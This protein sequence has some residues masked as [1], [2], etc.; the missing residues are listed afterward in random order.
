M[1]RELSKP[2]KTS[3]EARE[4]MEGAV[5]VMASPEAA[6]GVYSNFAVIKHTALEFVFDFIFNV[7][8]RGQLV[9]RV[10]TSPQHAKAFLD[11]LKQNIEQFDEAMK[12]ST[13][14]TEQPPPSPF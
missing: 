3:P 10:V 1:R 11:A 12:E 7:D 5:Q 9:A 14:S 2:D 4:T 6:R 13:P 8:G